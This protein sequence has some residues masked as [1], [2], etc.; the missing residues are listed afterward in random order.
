MA[1]PEI[2]T[3]RLSLTALRPGDAEAFHAYRSDPAVARY[4]F[5]EPASVDETARFLRDLQAVAFDTPGTWFQFGIR[6]RGSGLLVGDVG[7]R[8]PEEDARQVEIGFTV[9]P[10][11]QRRGYGSESVAGVL[12]HL[13]VALRKHRVFASV[14]P[15]NEASVKLLR[16]VGLRQEGHFR[17]SLWFKGAWVDDLVFAVLESEWIARRPRAAGSPSTRRDST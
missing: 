17:E 9:A 10:E 4:Q 1:G 16:R 8:F 3:R 7:V 13:F 12:E 2:P 15:R 14:D 11:H 6:L 5:R